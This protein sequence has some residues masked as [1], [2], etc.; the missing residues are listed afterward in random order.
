[1]V[2]IREPPSL[3]ATPVDACPDVIGTPLTFPSDAEA[4]VNVAVSATV[5]TEFAILTVYSNTEL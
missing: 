4:C 1:M 5:A 3:T 2:N